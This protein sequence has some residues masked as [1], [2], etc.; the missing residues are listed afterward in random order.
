MGQH[1]GF[2]GGE[3]FSQEI[4]PNFLVHSNQICL[5]LRFLLVGISQET[6]TQ[7]VQSRVTRIS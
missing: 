2:V 1:S 7:T 5:P 3:S 6:E 4:N